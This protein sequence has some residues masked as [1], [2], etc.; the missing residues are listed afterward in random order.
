MKVINHTSSKVVTIKADYDEIAKL[1]TAL[2]FWRRS[3]EDNEAKVLLHQVTNPE[4]SITK[5]ENVK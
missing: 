3:T 5:K 1:Q 4:I 2:D